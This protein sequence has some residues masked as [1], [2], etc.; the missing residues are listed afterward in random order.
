MNQTPFVSRAAGPVPYSWPTADS[1]VQW[2]GSELIQQRMRCTIDAA[3][4]SP[5]FRETSFAELHGGLREYHTASDTLDTT[6]P[7]VAT[8]NPTS[9]VP[10]GYIS[11]PTRH[12]LGVTVV[13]ARSNSRACSLALLSVIRWSSGRLKPY[14]T[15]PCTAH[16]DSR[17]PTDMGH[18]PH[19]AAVYVSISFTR[20]F[21]HRI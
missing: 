9:S 14:C 2:H 10:P 19:V 1:S 20:A 17:A 12:L 21:S 18:D 4:P 7:Y 11:V 5:A 15:A 3:F 13:R 8:R 16:S 6:R